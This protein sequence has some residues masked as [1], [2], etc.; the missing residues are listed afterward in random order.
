MNWILIFLGF[1]LLIVLHEAGHFFVAKATGMRVERFF[2]F[3]GPTIWSFKRG[4]TE[5]G[6]KAIPLGGYVKITGMN[7]EEEVPP[8]VEPR[9]YYRQPVWKRIAVIAAGPGVNIALAFAIFTFVYFTSA[10]QVTQSVDEIRDGSPAAKVLEPGDE[11]LAVDGRSY[12]GLDREARLER[13]AERVAGHEC[14]GRQVDGCVAATPAT[15]R[16]SRNGELRTISVRPEYDAANKRA[17]VGFAYG[18]EAEE[19]GFGTAVDRAW[20][21]VWLVTTKTASIFSRIFESEQRKEISGIVGVS[22][23]ANQTLDLGVE[24]SLLLLA[25][26]SLSL[27][28]INLLPILPLDGGHI[29]WALVEKLR[30]KPASLQV[31]ERATAIGIMLVVILMFIGLTNDI[32]RLNGEGFDVR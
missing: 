15:L 5:Y 21:T 32:G 16:I 7:P 27:G 6:V 9:A 1:S 23:V 18:T 13:F 26:V 24:R 11:I 4:E 8:E 12:P 29:F 14:A 22:D 17:L 25:L 2:L 19:I 20:D 28:L 3:F 10:Q 30:G 31:M